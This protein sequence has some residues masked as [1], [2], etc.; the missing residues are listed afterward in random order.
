MPPFDE[1]HMQNHKLIETSNV[2]MYLF[3]ERAMCDTETACSMFYNF[4]DSINEHMGLVDS[5]YQGLLADKNT[6][7]NN[8][9][10]LFMSGEQELKRIITQYTKKWCIKNRQQL[11]VADHEAFKKE[12][13]ELFKMVLT[14]IQN[15]TEH[16]YPMVREAKSKAA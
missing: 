5:L 2:L 1:L 8:T 14:R 15:E 16:L 6:D 4:M 10:R 11:K 12:T 7:A 13:Q 3:K 9:A